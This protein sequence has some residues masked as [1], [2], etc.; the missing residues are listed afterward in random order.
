MIPKVTVRSKG[1]LPP[2][3]GEVVKCIDAS[4]N[5]G[6][7]PVLLI[8]KEYVC[9]FVVGDH[10]HVAD[11]EGPMNKPFRLSRFRPVRCRRGTR[12]TV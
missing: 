4:S 9:Q 6:Q 8:G 5:P 2:F 12:K 10:I 3:P 11:E 7:S 1:A